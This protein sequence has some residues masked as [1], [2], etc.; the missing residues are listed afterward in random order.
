MWLRT[1]NLRE[2]FCSVAE[3]FVSKSSCRIAT[4]SAHSKVCN[5]RN[6]QRNRDVPFHI[7]Y[8]RYL[9][10]QFDIGNWLTSLFATLLLR[11]TCH[12]PVLVQKSVMWRIFKKAGYVTLLTICAKYSGLGVK[13]EVFTLVF[14]LICFPQRITVAFR[15]SSVDSKARI[16]ENPRSCFCC[17]TFCTGNLL[18]CSCWD[19]NIFICVFLETCFFFRWLSFV[20]RS[21]N[22]CLECY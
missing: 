9:V 22:G 14:F 15:L 5:L 11:K 12:H 13:F 2:T 21:S 1:C 18:T 20:L 3:S 16:M 7:F 10:L 4:F 17:F 19:S 8:S 6:L